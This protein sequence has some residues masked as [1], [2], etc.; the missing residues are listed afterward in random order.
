[1]HFVFSGSL[2]PTLCLGGASVDEVSSSSVPFRLV[3]C[4]GFTHVQYIISHALSVE[5]GVPMIHY[6]DDFLY[7]ILSFLTTSCKLI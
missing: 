7:T 1:M 6:S 5:F 4:F 2:L 3:Q